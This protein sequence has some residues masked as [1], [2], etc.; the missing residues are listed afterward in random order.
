[1]CTDH[2]H[3]SAEPS[4]SGGRRTG[5][6]NGENAARYPATSYQRERVRTRCF[7]RRTTINGLRSIRRDLRRSPF[8]ATGTRVLIGYRFPDVFENTDKSILDGSR[9][10]VDVTNARSRSPQP[11]LT[12]RRNG[13]F[14]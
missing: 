8:P 1:M 12:N 7:V 4:G 2:T 10:P 3:V 6:T 9:L 11:H 5:E 13:C 14:N